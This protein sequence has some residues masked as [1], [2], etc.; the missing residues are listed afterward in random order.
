MAEVEAK[1]LDEGERRSFNLGHVDVVQIGGAS[2]GRATLEPGWK[3][4]ECVKPIAKTDLCQVSHV[5][6]VISGTLAGVMHDGTTFRAKAGDTY[7]IGPGHDGWVEGNEPWI[8][9]EFESFKDY[10]KPAG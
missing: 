3:W 2:I 8:S 7:R 10:A 1:P 4:S 5:G 6:Y 9:V